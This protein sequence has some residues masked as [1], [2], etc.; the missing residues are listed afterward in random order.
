[1]ASS[2]FSPADLADREAIRDQLANYCR[3]VDRLDAALGY[4]VWHE[5][6][7]ADYGEGGYRGNGRGFI[8]YVISVHGRLLA[9]SH[10]ITNVLIHL[11]GDKAASE[12]YHFA[13]LHMERDGQLI[14]MRVEG[15]YLDQWSRRDGRWGIDHRLTIR[16]C[17]TVGS[18]TALSTDSAG[19]RDRQ[20][21]SY[22]LFGL[23][24]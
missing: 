4:A 21:P 22:K 16:D 10:Q 12:A 20:D 13:C 3:A 5:D 7:T 9:H 14:E 18:V 17:D 15:R 2:A 6:G 23:S 1:M 8:D 24:A 19:S 11:D